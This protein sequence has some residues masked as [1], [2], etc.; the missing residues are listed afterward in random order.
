VRWIWG[1]LILIPSLAWGDN[2]TVSWNPSESS[3]VVRHE[4]YIGTTPGDYDRIINVG[5]ET[6]VVVDEWDDGWNYARV[7]ACDENGCGDKSE[8]VTYNP[9]PDPPTEVNIKR[10]TQVIINILGD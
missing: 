3:D 6:S 2:A 7:S 4:V 1:L 9:L 5:I 10:G 8:E